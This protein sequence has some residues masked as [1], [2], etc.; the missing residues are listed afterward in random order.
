MEEMHANCIAELL[1]QKEIREIEDQNRRY[2]QGI[3]W[4]DLPP[5]GGFHGD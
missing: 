2:I 5:I 3:N 4:D 1:R